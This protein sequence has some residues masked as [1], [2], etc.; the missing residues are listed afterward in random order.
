MDVRD[1]MKCV[2]FT[3]ALFSSS[4]LSLDSPLPLP[5]TCCFAAQ[6]VWGM[7]DDRDRLKWAAF[8]TAGDDEATA[9][10]DNT[11]QV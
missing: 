5:S 6:V 8:N 3:K 10:I 11:A 4:L 2:A 9:S 1:H 7:L